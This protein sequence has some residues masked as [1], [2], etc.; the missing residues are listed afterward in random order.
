MELELLKMVPGGGSVAALIVTVILFLKQQEKSQAGL[1]L[2]A[3]TFNARVAA[4]QASSQD[5]IN[6]LVAQ[7]TENQKLYQDQ[8]QALI[9]RHLEVS[10][11]T[12]AAIKSLEV[13]VRELQS[14]CVSAQ[15]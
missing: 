4:T 11:E 7:A 1:S 6:R 5:Q 15:R 9:D 13:A 2:I 8:I 10:R 14:R 3:E 12:I